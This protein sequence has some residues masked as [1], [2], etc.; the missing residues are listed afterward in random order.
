MIQGKKYIKAH[1]TLSDVSFT[2]LTVVSYNSKKY[3][4]SCINT[5]GHKQCV[6]VS[7]IKGTMWASSELGAVNKLIKHYSNIHPDD[8]NQVIEL[9]QHYVNLLENWKKQNDKL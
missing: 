7:R 9:Y 6:P 4:Y 2:T 8:D 3:T 1:V 5:E